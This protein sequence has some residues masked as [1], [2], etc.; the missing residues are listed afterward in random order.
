[1]KKLEKVFYFIS[2]II[3]IYLLVSFI[4]INLNNGINGGEISKFN[5]FIIFLQILESR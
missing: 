5:I 4:E 1:M 3:I 2:L